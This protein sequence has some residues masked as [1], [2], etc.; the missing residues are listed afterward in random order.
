MILPLVPLNLINEALQHCRV[1]KSSGT[2]LIELFYQYLELNWFSE[3]ALF[4]IDI[5]THWNNFGARTNNNLED[6]HSKLNRLFK[7]TNPNFFQS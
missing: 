2:D 6:F 5:W 3:N 1:L 4:P 7:K